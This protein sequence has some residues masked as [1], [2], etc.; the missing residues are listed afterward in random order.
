MYFLYPQRIHFNLF[1]MQI[2]GCLAPLPLFFPSP[3]GVF[4]Q[5]WQEYPLSSCAF[6]LVNISFSPP[7][8]SA[9]LGFPSWFII[10]ELS[11]ESVIQ[12]VHY[13]TKTCLMSREYNSRACCSDV[14]LCFSKRWVVNSVLPAGLGLPRYRGRRTM[15]LPWHLLK[16]YGGLRFQRHI[17]F[18]LLE[19]L[20]GLLCIGVTY[21]LRLM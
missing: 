13:L 9:P 7:C 12:F 11:S 18:I 10:L 2:S 16:P 6:I 3:N 8:L 20:L 5:V 15:P 17:S 1:R 21:N 4:D 19:I 14:P